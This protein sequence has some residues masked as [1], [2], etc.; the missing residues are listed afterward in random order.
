M[1]RRGY[2]QFRFAAELMLVIDKQLVLSSE[3][4]LADP[5]FKRDRPVVRLRRVPSPG[6]GMQVVHDVSASQNE[7]AFFS[8]G[9]QAFADFIMERGWLGFID[10]ELNHW[11]IS[12]WIDVAQN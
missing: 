7:N 4:Q 1:I 10:A 6:I 3:E 11:N 8:Q 12:L 2:C 9:R 5:S